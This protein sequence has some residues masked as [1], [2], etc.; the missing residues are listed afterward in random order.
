MT[1]VP[2][3]PCWQHCSIF[4]YGIFSWINES[5]SRNIFSSMK[6]LP[7]F[8][9]LWSDFVDRP[10]RVT[11]WY[12]RMSSK[13]IGLQIFT[14]EEKISSC[15]Y[16]KS[17]VVS[18][19]VADMPLCCVSRSHRPMLQNTTSCWWSDEYPSGL[20]KFQTPFHFKTKRLL[21]CF[22][23]F[24]FGQVPALWF[25]SVLCSSLAVFTCR[26]LINGSY[27]T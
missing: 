19:N 3:K 6:Y 13:R 25:A 11:W 26:F 15:A 16:L 7:P 27:V 22:L 18:D 10:W 5:V 9:S 12:Q 14:L 1:T 24:G 23:Y 4:N 20:L 21:L 2:G 8:I 17:S